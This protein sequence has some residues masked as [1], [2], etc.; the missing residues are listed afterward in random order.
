M[1]LP[2]GGLP[3]GVGVQVPPGAPGTPGGTRGQKLC[4]KCG[5]SGHIAV[6]CPTG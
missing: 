4:F 6:H 2:P 5:L 1:P 3:P